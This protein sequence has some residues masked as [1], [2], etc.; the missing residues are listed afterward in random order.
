MGPDIRGASEHW[1]EESL[2]EYLPDA[3]AYESGDERLATL[4]AQY[5]AVMTKFPDLSE[6][7]LQDLARLVLSLD[8]GS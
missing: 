3:P 7:E 2:M 6:K 1:T 8:P 4:R 5:P